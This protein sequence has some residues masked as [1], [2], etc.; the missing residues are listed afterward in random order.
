MKIDIGSAIRKAR[1]AAGINQA[2]VAEACGWESQGRVSNY[3]RGLREPTLSDLDKIAK[4]VRVRLVDL[5]ASGIGQPIFSPGAESKETIPKLT[6][7]E[8]VLLLA[9]R[10]LPLQLKDAIFAI[11]HSHLDDSI[12]QVAQFLGRRNPEHQRKIE[13]KLITKQIISR[14]KAT[15]ERPAKRQRPK[16]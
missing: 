10:H 9:Y 15:A 1:M 4:A 14:S 6:P 13:P 5:L 12:P 3:E 8:D 2:A 11:I 7:E 16:E